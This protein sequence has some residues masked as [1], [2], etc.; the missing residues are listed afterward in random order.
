MADQRQPTDGATISAHRKKIKQE[1]KYMNELF[2]FYI[3]TAH[4][5][6]RPIIF[7]VEF[8]IL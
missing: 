5:L 7:I 2:I 8:S 1:T 6:E 4:N 3:R